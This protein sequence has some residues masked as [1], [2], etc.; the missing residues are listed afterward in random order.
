M[1]PKLLEL[2]HP[3]ELLDGRQVRSLD[4]FDQ[5]NF[6]DRFVGQASNPARERL[7][8]QGFGGPVTTF[9]SHDLKVLTN[10]PDQEIR[11]HANRPDR[12][13][14]FELIDVAECFPRI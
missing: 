12:V 3:G 1:N 2:P 7:E 10:R 11:Q 6:P 9:A 4:V 8:A 5:L 13:H 14:Q